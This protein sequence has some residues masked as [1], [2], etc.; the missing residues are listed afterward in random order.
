MESRVRE[1]K[2]GELFKKREVN[3]VTCHSKAG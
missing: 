1:D 2:G 3:I